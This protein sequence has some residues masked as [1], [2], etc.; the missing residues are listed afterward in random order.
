M[1]RL[2][3][4][5]GREDAGGPGEWGGGLLWLSFACGAPVA[6]L[7]RPC[8]A[9]GERQQR[10]PSPGHTPLS[11]GWP[12][13]RAPEEASCGRSRV[14]L[15]LF[16]VG[17]GGHSVYSPPSP[18]TP[19]VASGVAKPYVELLGLKG[20]WGE[21][22]VLSGGPG[23]RERFPT[24][25][26]PLGSGASFRATGVP[27]GQPSS[28]FTGCSAALSDPP[29]QPP[30]GGVPTWIPAV[31]GLSFPTEAGLPSLPLLCS[32]FLS[33]EGTSSS[34]ACLGLLA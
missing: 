24:P 1:Y 6:R 5:V 2:S 32:A 8:Q 7:D 27:V 25:E 15:W 10:G 16:K 3:S 14:R 18:P 4:W 28:A 30:P 17:K 9:G 34:S 21:P 22:R 31:E 23:L 33:Q 20:S 26:F 29:G 13:G 19:A 12:A 11:R